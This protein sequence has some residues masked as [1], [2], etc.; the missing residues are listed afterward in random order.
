MK[1]ILLWWLLPGLFLLIFWF[2]IDLYRILLGSGKNLSVGRKLKSLI[3]TLWT[4]GFSLIPVLNIILSIASIIMIFKP[5][6][7]SYL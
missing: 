4:I 2:F 6:R 7:E 3:P 1:I 5:D